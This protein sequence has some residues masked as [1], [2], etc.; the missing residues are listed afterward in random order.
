MILYTNRDT[1]SR[2]KLLA[3]GCSMTDDLRDK[4]TVA[5]S[6]QPETK[7]EQPMSYSCPQC[8]ASNQKGTNCTNC[9]WHLTEG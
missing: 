8:G 5:Q 2:F 3:E 7:E 9:G 6:G 4:D 1:E